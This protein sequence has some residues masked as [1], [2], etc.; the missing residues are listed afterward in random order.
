[1]GVLIEDAVL[2]P[3]AIVQAADE[4]EQ[5]LLDRAA[6]SV[7]GSAWEVGE[8]AFLWTQRYSQGRTDADFAQHVGLSHDQVKQKRLVYEAFAD[9]CD[10]Y[11]NLSWSHFYVARTWDDAA[12]CL[13]WAEE[14]EARVAEM[15]AWRRMCNGED[16][17]I[18]AD[19]PETGVGGQTEQDVP[20]SQPESPLIGR[21]RSFRDSRVAVL[22]PATPAPEA[23]ERAVRPSEAKTASASPKVAETTWTLSELQVLLTGAEDTLVGLVEREK[24]AAWH[25]RRAYELEHCDGLLVGIWSAYP[26]KVGKGAAVLAIKRALQ[27]VDAASLVGAVTE[28][29]QAMSDVEDRYVPHCATWMNGERWTDD[30]NEWTAH[31]RG[32]DGQSI[33]ASLQRFVD[34]GEQ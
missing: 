18:E 13:A 14:N 8:C 15:K 31:R 16:L 19:S 1:M 3:V 34:G 12:E 30:R 7:S 6:A 2:A 27:K 22:V 28:F 5:Q 17:T 9:V 32:G 33:Q 25:R 4:T 24:L 11:H 20:E 29:A 23:D 26:R 10:S 21:R